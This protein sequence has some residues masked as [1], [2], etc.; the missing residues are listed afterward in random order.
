MNKSPISFIIRIWSTSRIYNITVSL[1]TSNKSVA[2]ILAQW[3]T[4]IA[5]FYVSIYCT[6]LFLPVLD[7]C[8]GT[9]GAP[10]NI[11]FSDIT[12][13]S[14]VVQWDDVDNAY[15]Y[16]LNWNDDDGAGREAM[17]ARTSHTITGLTPNMVYRVTVFA[18]NVCG[19]G[20]ISDVFQVIT[21]ASS[22]SS[23]TAPTSIFSSRTRVTA[24]SPA[25]TIT[26][27]SA[28]PAAGTLPAGT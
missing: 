3:T 17:T 14:V 16:V 8:T 7:A 9:P 21:N 26:L 15:H 4:I 22:M 10:V 27:T 25:I 19:R 18:R 1:Y 20:I 6:Y 11:R 13:T 5:A 12:T 23:Y 24:N 28:M 2:K